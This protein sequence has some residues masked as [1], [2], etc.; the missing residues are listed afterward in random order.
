MIPEDR[1]SLLLSR[2]NHRE[3]LACCERHGYSEG[4]AICDGALVI[5]DVDDPPPWF[6]FERDDDGNSVAEHVV[7]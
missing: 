7:S 4:W 5:Y 1:L 3:A 6:Q 2:K